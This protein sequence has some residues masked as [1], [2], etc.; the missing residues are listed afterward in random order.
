[1]IP[2][3][4]ALR[5]ITSQVLES[6]PLRQHHSWAQHVRGPAGERF[7]DGTEQTQVAVVLIFVVHRTHA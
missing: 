5:F 6:G 1:M 7:K 2:S 3:D 4:S